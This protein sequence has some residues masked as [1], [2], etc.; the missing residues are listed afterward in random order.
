MGRSAKH[1]AVGLAVDL[2][3]CVLLWE[4]GQTVTAVHFMVA[5]RRFDPSVGAI[6]APLVLGAVMTAVG[7]SMG[8]VSMRRGRAD[9]A[10]A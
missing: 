3:A 5:L 2:A 10:S 1:A 7:A 6:E 4:A 8:L 9:A